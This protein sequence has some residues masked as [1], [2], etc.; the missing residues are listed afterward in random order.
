M[1]SYFYGETNHGDIPFVVKLIYEI[2]EILHLLLHQDEFQKIVSCFQ[3][4]NNPIFSALSYKIFEV[5]DKYMQMTIATLQE[6]V[7]VTAITLMFD[8][9]IV[10][11]KDMEE[12]HRIIICLA[13]CSVDTGIQLK[14]SDWG[15]EETLISWRLLEKGLAEIDRTKSV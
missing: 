10:S 13:K 11:C 6:D 14:V 15:K 5:E 3:N 1:I 4:R 12:K 8:G 9:A 2:H 7:G